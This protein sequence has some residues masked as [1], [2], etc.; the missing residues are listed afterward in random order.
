MLTHVTA[1]QIEQYRNKAMP[2]EE[3]LAFDRHLAQC[4]G[5]REQLSSKR[6]VSKLLDGLQ[7]E[8]DSPQHLTYDQM[9]AYIDAKAADIDREIVETHVELCD[10]CASELG[11]LAA[12]AQVMSAESEPAPIA[13]THWKSL[14]AISQPR[15]I[16][17]PHRDDKEQP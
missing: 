7:A 12:F 15:K 3:L 14:G 4:A 1:R 10:R 2:P 6:D 9:A 11:D 17:I 13:S 5:C 8:A 16:K